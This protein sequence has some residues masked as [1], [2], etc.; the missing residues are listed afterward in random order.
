MLALLVL[1]ASSV[2]CAEDDR[3]F[4]PDKALHFSVSVGLSAAAYAAAALLHQPVE[5]KLATAVGLSIFAGVAKELYDLQGFGDPSPLDLTWD[6]LG[7]AVGAFTA[8]LV[9]WLVFS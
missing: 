6:L 4:A 1:L 3:P 2:A 7:T 5:V 8:W 9:D